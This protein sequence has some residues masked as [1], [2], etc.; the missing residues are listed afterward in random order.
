MQHE[1]DLDEEDG[2][3]VSDNDEITEEDSEE[4][5]DDELDETIIENTV[6]RSLEQGDD[7]PR[8]STRIKRFPDRYNDYAFFT[9]EEA[10]NSKNRWKWMR[11]VQEEKDLLKKNQTWELV[12]SNEAREKKFLTSRWVFQIK[13]E[14]KNIKP[15]PLQKDANKKTILITKNYTVPWSIVLH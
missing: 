6:D 2:E 1:E 14:G 3:T 8:R 7:T 12:N 10:M 11:I 13:E 4:D 9:H 15:D 5:E